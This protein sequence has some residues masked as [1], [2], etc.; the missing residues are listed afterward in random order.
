M[1]RLESNSVK[2]INIKFIYYNLMH[3]KKN[4]WVSIELPQKNQ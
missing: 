3:D 2:N 4:S 1:L